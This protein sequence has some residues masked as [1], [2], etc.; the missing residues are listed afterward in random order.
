MKIYIGAGRW[1]SASSFVLSAILV[2]SGL[3]PATIYGGQ[4]NTGSVQGTVTDEKGA[5]IVGATVRVFNTTSKFDQTVTTDQ[6]G[7]Y[8]INN[9]PFNTYTVH[10]IAD[11]FQE[12]DT[13]VDVHSALPAS[14]NVT[15]K[16]GEASL[17]VDVNATTNHE[18][19]IDPDKVETSTQLSG[20]LIQRS[21]GSS[22]AS[23]VQNA[24]AKAPGAVQGDNGRVFL[25]GQEN[26]LLY[27]VD[28]IPISDSVTPTNSAGVDLQTANSIEV[29]TGD[30]P[31]KF[32]NR[33]GG[34]VSVNTPVMSSQPFTGSLTM[35]GGSFN[36]AD[37]GATAGGHIGK[38]GFFF[39]AS[40][41]TTDRY[42]DSVTQEN[43]HNTGHNEHEFFKFDYAK[44]ANDVFRFGFNFGQANFGVAN[45]PFQQINGQSQKIGLSDNSQNFSWQHTFST[46]TLL[47][48]AA[49]RR[50]FSSDLFSNDQAT[51]VFAQ[52]HRTLTNDGLLAS[53]S[54]Q[55]AKHTLEAGFELS[56]FPIKENFQFAVTDPTAFDP[57]FPNG[58]PNPVLQFTLANKFLFND[59]RTGNEESAY[60]QDRWKPVNNLTLDLGLRYDNYNLLVHANQLSPRIGAAY[61]IDKTKTVLRASFDRFFAPPPN[62][63]LLLASSPQAAALSP[64][65]ISGFKPILPETTSAYEAGAQ[66][67]ITKYLKLDVAYFSRFVDN[68]GDRDQFLDTPVVF[69]VA[70]AKGRMH[71][72]ETKLDTAEIHGF[73]GNASFSNGRAIGFTPIV[74]GLFLDADAIASLTNPGQ[75][76]FLDHDQR[77]S[78]QWQV[79]YNHHKS[80]WWAS[81]TGRYDS[82]LP[83]DL[84][85]DRAFYE[86]Q[87]PL[88]G[89]T[90]QVLDQID[91]TRGRVK[92]RTV[93]N[94]STGIDIKRGDH[95][96]ISPQFDVL[97]LTN[98]FYLYTFESVFSGTRLGA[99]RTYA[100]HLTFRFK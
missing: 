61:Y 37:I 66:Q 9:V 45:R 40:A 56:R 65:G 97:N 60:V 26:G 8:K 83:V 63:N 6:T 42:L 23:G 18:Q 35:N 22:P 19:Q 1:R 32:G 4:G 89:F 87:G 36:A 78:A 58:Q 99:P 53:I 34:V 96:T 14:N 46:T 39:S 90:D 62:E 76:F 54:H 100:G 12:N 50:Q 21:L 24:V 33:L 17:T 28:G 2:L 68:V 10:V 84:A 93:W 15:L 3:V 75:A 95:L 5:V 57:L 47:S 16:V 20:T 13:Q 74:G 55:T 88:F 82:G 70:I 29:S 7:T 86:A 27:V 11:G 92:P 44:G 64:L 52:Q 30:I 41:A 69:P 43:F 31:A 98:E 38:L 73:S 77:T 80:G 72:I 25:R 67:Q 79:D 48:V 81:L 71:G 94:F 59:Q 85:G 91:F 49:Y 51:P